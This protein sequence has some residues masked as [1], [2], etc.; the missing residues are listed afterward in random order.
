M[1]KSKYMKYKAK[2][3]KLM[4]QR[5]GASKG[6]STRNELVKLEKYT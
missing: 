2:Y 1:Y 3:L 6:D 4:K 5:G